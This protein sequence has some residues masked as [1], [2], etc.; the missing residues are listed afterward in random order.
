MKCKI[1]LQDEFFLDVNAF[2]LRLPSEGMRLLVR[3]I[4]AGSWCG[5]IMAEK[6][7]C[8]E[9]SHPIRLAERSRS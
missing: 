5:E 6:I 3:N 2:V 4:C 9:S 1:H 7:E 8:T